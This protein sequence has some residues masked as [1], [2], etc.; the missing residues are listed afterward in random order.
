MAVD[1]IEYSAAIGHPHMHG[2]NSLITVFVA[3]V[4]TSFSAVIAAGKRRSAPSTLGLPVEG[5]KT[6]HRTVRSSALVYSRE[7]VVAMARSPLFCPTANG[8]A[9]AAKEISRLLAGA[10]STRPSGPAQDRARITKS[11]QTDVA[12]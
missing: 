4:D 6:S 5:K 11:H 1:F 12:R 10:K 7:G 9:L 2:S 3:H 8:R